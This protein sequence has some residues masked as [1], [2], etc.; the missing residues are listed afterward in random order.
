M[1]SDVT[2]S[3]Y[4]TSC[5]AAADDYIERSTRFGA[6]DLKVLENTP[7]TRRFRIRLRHSLEVI[8]EAKD[9]QGV[10]KPGDNDFS[11]A[12]WDWY[13]KQVQMQAQAELGR[14]E[15]LNDLVATVKAQPY[16]SISARTAIR[17]HPRRLFHTYTC[18]DCHGSGHVTCHGCGGSGA[19]TCSGCGGGGRV[20]CTSCYGSGSVQETHQVRDY[21][22][23]Y[24]T[25]TRHRPCYRCSGGRVTC[26]G[27]GGTGRNT[28]RTCGGS[29]HLTC[30]TCG[31]HGYLTRITSTSTYTQPEFHGFYPEGTPDYVHDAL[32]KAGFSNLQ[33]YGTIEFEAADVTREHSRAD[34][35]Y[36]STINFCELLL[37]VAGHQ[38]TWI[39]YGE[40][41]RI[42]DAG[43]ILEVLLKDDFQRLDAL[44]AGWSCLLPW[45]HRHARRAVA[46]FMES[47][48]HQEVVDA[49]H[50]GLAPGVI[51]EKVNRS[52]SADYI[53][54]SLTRLRQIVQVVGRW[55]SLKWSIGIAV[56]SIPFTIFGIVLIEHAKPHTMLATQEH[57]V[58]FPWAS[59]P[60]TPWTIALLTVPFSV[61]GWLFA[62]RMSHRWI[63]HAGGK[64]LLAWAH[65]KGFLI[66]KWTALATIAATATVA[67]NFFERWPIWMDK[68]GKL[69]GA[70]ATFQQPQMIEPAL[71]QP[72]EPA[73]H[74]SPHRPRKLKVPGSN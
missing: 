17:T 51:V 47:E 21:T 62:K 39:L 30:G 13:Q 66:G 52:V 26:S 57:M 67:A 60:Q 16:A 31:G 24:R 44:G 34:F 68:D 32:C 40:P 73:N 1:G 58:L 20:S 6:A 10:L 36:Q 72:R 4:S 74:R 48:V 23:H 14:E 22:G 38:S 33:Q 41:P 50:Q 49:D 43:G 27:C 63:K 59:G 2:L 55:S 61:T 35:K 15:T 53:E 45:F 7:E 46:P 18:G 28:C 11:S 71:F 8:S 25:E 54:R 29:G 5:L 69:Y 56:A 70:V 19:V 42:Y 65:Q 64:Q 3:K 12:D 37:E 9:Y